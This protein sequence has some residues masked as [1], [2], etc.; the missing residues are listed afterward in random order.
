MKTMM[1]LAA[2]AANPIDAWWRK[3]VGLAL[4]YLAPS[5]LADSDLPKELVWG[6]RI[7]A[8]ALTV[9]WVIYFAK[10]KK[11]HG[12]DHG[13]HGE[14]HGGEG[15]WLGKFGGWATAVLAA[16]LVGWFFVD[17][18]KSAWDWVVNWGGG[19]STILGSV[20]ASL[21]TVGLVVAAILFWRTLYDAAKKVWEWVVKT[22]NS[23]LG[24]V[25]GGESFGWQLMGAF[26]ISVGVNGEWLNKPSSYIPAGI[27]ALLGLYV[28]LFKL[29]GLGPGGGKL[30]LKGG[31][32]SLSLAKNL[33][34]PAAAGQQPP[35]AAPVVAGLKPT[36]TA[37]ETVACNRCGAPKH[38]DQNCPHCGHNLR[39]E[40]HRRNQGG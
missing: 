29:T 2:T 19:E 17:L 6:I 33:R 4:T 7:L 14:G 9:V 22:Y 24:T 25:H 34:E 36:P 28:L 5:L 37:P 21:A 26:Y 38:P 10:V 40:M 20:W 8:T 12:G 35:A 1:M 16:A 27:S 18:G 13:G 23:V 15:N 3:V 32:S 11:G 39:R 30:L 31:R